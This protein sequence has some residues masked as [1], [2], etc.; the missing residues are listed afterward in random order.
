M[1]AMPKRLQTCKLQRVEVQRDM[2][3]R[4]GSRTSSPCESNCS[5]GVLPLASRQRRSASGPQRGGVPH[6]R[7]AAS[8]HGHVKVS[9]YR[10]G[11]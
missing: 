9:D 2:S 10:Q 11:L 7:L 3:Y 6:G 1:V 4:D 8:H 5:L